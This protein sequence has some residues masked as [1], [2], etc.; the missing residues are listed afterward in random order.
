MGGQASSKM[1]PVRRS[2][3]QAKERLSELL[4]DP[5]FDFV[6]ESFAHL[7]I[8]TVSGGAMSFFL[9]DYALKTNRITPKSPRFAR[10]GKDIIVETRS[11]DLGLTFLGMFA[12]FQAGLWKI[13]HGYMKLDPHGEKLKELRSLLIDMSQNRTDGT[14]C[15]KSVREQVKVSN[16]PT[17]ISHDQLPK[18]NKYGDVI[19]EDI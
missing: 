5:A 13:R 10:V 18:L 15:P 3:A 11:H 4:K 12:G 6:R 9:V 2:N 16:V 7:P 1:D 8:W 19:E 14:S 17:Q